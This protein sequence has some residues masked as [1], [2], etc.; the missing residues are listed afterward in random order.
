MYISQAQIYTI[1]HPVFPHPGKL[2]FINACELEWT[3]LSADT[4]QVILPRARVG[5]VFAGKEWAE[6]KDCAEDRTAL[7]KYRTAS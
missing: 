6:D 1:F 3:Y 7:T 4:G 2:P 5:D